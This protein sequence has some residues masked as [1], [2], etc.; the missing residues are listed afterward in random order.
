MHPPPPS[1]GPPSEGR[2]W[3]G[4]AMEE[5]MLWTITELMHLTRDELCDLAS[6]IALTLPELDVGTLARSDALAS[7]ENI[8]LVLILRDLTP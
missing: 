1:Q 4:Q 8:R 7:F 5:T 2:D 3:R 6:R